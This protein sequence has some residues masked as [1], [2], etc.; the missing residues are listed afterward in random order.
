MKGGLAIAKPPG[1]SAEQ[2]IRYRVCA[3]RLAASTA[4]DGHIADHE[5]GALLA[6]TDE[7][8]VAD[9]TI[10]RNISRRLPAI[11]IS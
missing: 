2:G 3:T 4:G 1:V 5:R 11:V 9:P 6:A 10:S 7:D 8:V